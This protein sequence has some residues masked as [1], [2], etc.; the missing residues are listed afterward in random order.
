[1][2][3]KKTSSLFVGNATAESIQTDL[4]YLQARLGSDLR[5]IDAAQERGGLGHGQLPAWDFR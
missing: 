1:M 2:M 3:L 4:D 5:Q